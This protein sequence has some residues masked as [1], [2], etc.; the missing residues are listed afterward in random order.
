MRLGFVGTGT[1]SAAMVRGLCAAPQDGL[2]IL[3]S[4]RSERVSSALAAAFPAVTRGENTQAVVSGSD[5]VVLGVR[6]DQLAVACEGLPFRKGQIVVSLLAGIDPAQVAAVIPVPVQV[7]RA[8]PLPMIERREGPIVLQDPPPEVRALF[9]DLGRVIVARDGAEMA[10]FGV[11]SGLMSSFLELGFAAV[12]WLAGRGVEPE[13]GRDYI[14]ELARG[15]AGTA[16]RTAPTD[17]AA[18]NAAHE[19]PGGINEYCRTALSEA[20]A[21]ALLQ[22]AMTQTEA[23]ARTLAG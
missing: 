17:F 16:M 2:S 22:Q 19:T 15:L 3:V 9:A 11:A 1:I 13:A 20:G 6:P 8:T 7:C 18:L 4:P 5:I 21:F 23:H 14:A 12:S 10:A